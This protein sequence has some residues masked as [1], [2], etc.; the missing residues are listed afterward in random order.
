MNVLVWSA[1]AQVTFH[2]APLAQVC[3]CHPQSIRT[4]RIFSNPTTEQAVMPAC[5]SKSSSSSSSSSSAPSDSAP[6][7]VAD[8]AP[9][10][11]PATDRV[12]G[13]ERSAATG[14]QRTVYLW[15]FSHTTIP[16]RPQPTGFTR[17]SFALAVI[18]AYEQTG[19]VVLQ[20]AVFME[21]H[22]SSKSDREQRL[23]FHMI[24]ETEHACRWVE[25]AKHLRNGHKIFASVATSSAR[26]SYW[27]A[28]SYLFVPS[29]KKPKADLDADYLLSPGHED[30]PQQLANRRAGMRRI[31]PLEIYTAIVEHGLNSLVKLYAHAARQHHSGDSCWLHH[32]MKQPEKKLKEEISKALAMAGAVAR[33]ATDKQNH[34]ETLRA[35]LT[36]P[37]TCDGHAIPGWEHILAINGFNVAH[38]RLS[39]LELFKAG[40]GKCLNHMYIG[41]PSSGKTGLTRPLIALFGAYAFLKPQVGTSFALQGLIGSKAV[42]W[43]DFRWPHQPLAWADLLNMLDNEPFNVGVPKNDGQTDFRWNVDGQDGVIAILTANVNVVYVTDHAVNTM[44]TKAWDERFAKMLHFKVPLVNPDKRYKKWFRCVHC[45]ALWILEFDTPQPGDLCH[46]CSPLPAHDP[47]K[48][49]T[50]P[51]PQSPDDART[52]AAS[53]GSISSTLPVVPPLPSGPSACGFDDVDDWTFGEDGQTQ[54]DRQDLPESPLQAVLPIKT[55]V[56]EE[57]QPL[58]KLNLVCARAG[59][60]P[61]VFAEIEVPC[62]GWRCHITA[63]GFTAAGEGSSQ[64]AA[65]RN[66]ASALLSILP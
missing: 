50:G 5:L 17:L 4:S 14:D 19:K 25:M 15:T 27:A 20:W 29:A 21:V 65:K 22:P 55:P 48:S 57:E 43:N 8:E 1:A 47:K 38:Y 11:T 40:G 42:I 2:R 64:K 24:V 62:T 49:R 33:L 39:I 56:M 59:D 52:V 31:T 3:F 58:R 16:G 10:P 41:E 44:E 18:S 26:K 32:C 36:A 34:I 60:N 46:P 23:H 35:A 9:D 54:P 37:C 53:C 12:D 66:A 63:M 30:P 51:G 45:Y 7:I 6:N 13:H 61:P 28:F